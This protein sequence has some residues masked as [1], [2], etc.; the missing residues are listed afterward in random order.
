MRR[1]SI[2]KWIVLTALSLTVV[3][4]L[5]TIVHDETA[6]A[7]NQQDQTATQGSLQAL[8]KD[9][10]P[11]IVVV[12][13]LAHQLSVWRV[14]P[15]KPGGFAVVRAPGVWRSLPRQD[16][17]PTPSVTRLFSTGLRMS[18]RVANLV[19]S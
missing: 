14:D 6:A 10:K 19:I 17:W 8:D 4:M 9:G 7:A 5:S 2:L 11:E 3:F 16:T 15:A 18:P 13:N 1:R 12:D